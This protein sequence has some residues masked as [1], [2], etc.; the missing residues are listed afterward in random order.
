[1]SEIYIPPNGLY[2]R[3]LG[4][5]SQR[6]LFSRN[7]P[8][9]AFGDI[10]VAENYEDQYFTLIHGT[11]SHKG[12]Y[13]IKSKVSGKVLCSR[14]KGIRVS[15]VDGDG[16]YDDKLVFSDIRVDVLR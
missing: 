13:A 12:L 4:Y 9:P 8:E 5:S 1:M 6:V 11:G 10:I 7:Q 3:L 16:K 2:F 14:N 15:H